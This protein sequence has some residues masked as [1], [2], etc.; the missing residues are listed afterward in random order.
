[1]GKAKLTP[2]LKQCMVTCAVG[3]S[4]VCHIGFVFGFPGVLLPALHEDHTAIPLTKVGDSWVA[5]IVSISML[6]GNFVTP[7][8]MGRYGRKVA[9]ISVGL[10]AVV[11]WFVIALSVNVEM[12]IFARFLQGLSVGLMLPLRSVLVGEY[13]SPKYR[14]GFLTTISLAQGFG[15]FLVHLV[16]SLFSWQLT[17]IACGVAAFLSTI[18]AFY[19]PESPSWLAVKGRYEE[20]TQAFRWLRGEGE[21]KEL[22]EMI[23]SQTKMREEIVDKEKVNRSKTVENRSIVRRKEFYKPIVIIAHCYLMVQVSGNATM[24][25]FSVEIISVMMGSSA[26]VHVWMVALDTLRIITNFTAIFIINRFKRRIIIF[27]TGGLC[28]AV[29]L[30]MA[31]Y[32]YFKD[33]ISYDTQWIPGCL[34]VM[35]FFCIG[36]G[37]TPMSNVISGEVIPLEFRSMISSIGVFTL[38]VFM[39]MV[40]KTFP[41]L[42]D[43][44]GLYGIYAIYSAILTYILILLWFILPE[45][46]GKT[47]QQIENELKGFHHQL[48]DAEAKISLKQYGN[49]EE[50]RS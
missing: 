45:T 41:L 35:Q 3:S 16:G 40:L 47:L 20:C 11:S 46:S 7:N 2:F 49:G 15:I 8:V 6:I 1:M 26:N 28:T 38:A 19:L 29:H 39:F 14:G 24:P 25:A 33:T 30:A 48:E 34:V 37:M 50:E 22:E 42:L 17:S 10:P 31:V 4:L 44:I 32:M 12:L 23:L 43:S 13:S 18:I 21:E 9:H 5:S 27:A 36:L